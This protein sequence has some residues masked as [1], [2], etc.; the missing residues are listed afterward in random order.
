MTSAITGVYPV[1]ALMPFQEDGLRE[2]PKPWLTHH[3]PPL[4]LD[5]KLTR[6]GLG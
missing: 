3:Q 5:Q 2:Y 6:D 4:S 1:H